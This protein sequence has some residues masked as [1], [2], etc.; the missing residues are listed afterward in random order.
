MS[1]ILNHV[2]IYL[3]SIANEIDIL[4]YIQ[5]LLSNY[6]NLIQPHNLSNTDT[7]TWCS[8]CAAITSLLYTT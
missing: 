8:V 6:F 3:V 5:I 2:F 4:F 1:S 7:L